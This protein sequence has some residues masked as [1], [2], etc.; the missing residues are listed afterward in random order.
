M[1][2]AARLRLIDHL[3]EKGDR[4]SLAALE[5]LRPLSLI[6]RIKNAAYHWSKP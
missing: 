2:S 4:R 3:I 1:V 5:L 6:Q